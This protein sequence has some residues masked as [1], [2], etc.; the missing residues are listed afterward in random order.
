MLTRLLH[1]LWPIELP[2]LSTILGEL[3]Y[4]GADDFIGEA[5]RRV[6]G[7]DPDARGFDYYHRELAAGRLSRAVLLARLARSWEYRRTRGM[8]PPQLLTALHRSRVA[9]VRRLPPADVIVDLGGASQGHPEG[10]L[11]V[12][13]YPH[14]FRTLTIVEPPRRR[15]HRIYHKVCDDSTAPVRVGAGEVRYL[16]RS[17]SDLAPIASESVDLVFCGQAIEHVARED[18]GRVFDEVRRVLRSGGSFCF[19][20]PNRAIT[21]IEVG[22]HRFINPDHRHEYTHG[23]LV[24]L[25]IHHGFNIAETKGLNHMPR[26]ARTRRFEREEMAANTGIFDEADEC[27]LLY[28]HCTKQ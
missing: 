11:V 24:E 9:M 16:F 13:G 5:Y 7:R 12:M 20:T 4:L 1:R 14:V 17:M 6:L 2:D 25:L 23:E 8:P 3:E 15:R 22:E 21:R 27:Y 19:D 18:A 26:S 10:A 28:F